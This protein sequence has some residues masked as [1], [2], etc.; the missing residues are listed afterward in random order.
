MLRKFCKEK[1]YFIGLHNYNSDYYDEI[2]DYLNLKIADT[3]SKYD[4]IFISSGDLK[5]LK[6]NKNISDNIIKDYLKANK[7]RLNN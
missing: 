7:I 1:I 6:V 2:Y 5:S 4:I 3:A